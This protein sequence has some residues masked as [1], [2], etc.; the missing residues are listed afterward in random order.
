MIFPLRSKPKSVWGGGFFLKFLPFFLFCAIIPFEVINVKLSTQKIKEI[1]TGAVC[2]DEE[3][4]A[5]TPYRFTREQ[6]EFYRDR[7][8]D[9][10]QR[11]LCSAGMRL[12]FTTD[13]EHLSL[14]VVL[15]NNSSR[16]FFSFDV[17]VNG[18]L[19][20]CLDNFAGIEFPANYTAID[21]PLGEFSK[22]FSL[23]KGE[24]Q[25]CVY[26]PWA[27]KTVI[28]S[29]EL[30]DGAQITPIK[31][32]K[33][34]LAFGDSITQGYDATRPSLRYVS[35]LCDHLGAAE[36]NKAIGGEIFVGGLGAL[37]DDISPDYITVAYGTNDWSKTERES[38]RRNAKEFYANLT[39]LYPEAKI[40]ALA[41]IW[42]KDLQLEKKYG[43]FAD[44][45]A[46]IRE[47]TAE[48]PQV[49]VIPCF[50]AVPHDET[51]YS[52]LYLHPNDRGFAHYAAHLR[53]AISDSL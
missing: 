15:T 11:A 35:Q 8:P 50:D 47:I 7:N 23:G 30:D 17:F 12:W 18:K 1:I 48:F 37:P 19:M 16:K 45:E 2:F 29:M 44:V 39:R 9:F 21:L 10:Y 20:D 13:S 42:R 33:L 52:D 5:L 22:T 32:D 31:P 4:G 27:E 28:K 34:L 3:N 41:P 26:L 25:V 46:D 24:K 40:F 53:A 36:L 6:L 43:L 51:Y 49:T 38:S 14:Q